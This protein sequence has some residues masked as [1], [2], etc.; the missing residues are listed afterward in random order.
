MRLQR[1]VPITL[2]A[3]SVSAPAL[4]QLATTASADTV[5]ARLMSFD[6]NDDGR[7]MRD[8]LPERM[9]NLMAR[10]DASS[11]GV[12]DHAELLRLATTPGP[13][14]Q[15]RLG[16]QAERYGFRDGFSFED[17]TSQLDNALD[18][19][20]LSASVREEADDIVWAFQ[21]AAANRPMQDLL[22]EM[23]QV[24]TSEQLNDF[25]AAIDRQTLS[26]P[27]IRQGSATFFGATAAEAVGKPIVTAHLRMA[28]LQLEGYLDRYGLTSAQRGRAVAAIGRFNARIP[29]RWTDDERSA[30]LEQ[31]R[32]VLNDEQRDDL[33]AAL[34]R[35]HAVKLSE[36][37]LVAQL[38]DRLRETVQTAEQ[39]ADTFRIVDLVL[40]K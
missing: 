38:L 30:L 25:K 15:V 21:T 20:R 16:L 22:A 36:G 32:D 18:D 35:R 39:P 7:L 10:G 29:G 5:L 40:R 4:A 31:L 26:V 12:L 23:A 11:D 1:V 17:T 37:V 8:E 27:A 24:L 3:V 13:Q 28:P 14:L 9:H 2:L 6:R 19:L 33:H 34:Q